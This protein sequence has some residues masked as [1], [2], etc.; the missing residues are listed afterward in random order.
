MNGRVVALFLSVALA[1]GVMGGFVFAA[2]R[3]PEPTRVPAIVL[4]SEPAPASQNESTGGGTQGEVKGKDDFQGEPL[5]GGLSA[6]GGRVDPTSTTRSTSAGD[7]PEEGR[8]GSV[9]ARLA[10]PPAPMPAGNDPEDSGDDDR[11][12]DNG[13][14]DG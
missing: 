4:E 1:V 8:R 6:S 13:E 9:G 2:I 12:E 10:P 11:G 7:D 5:E 3:A 14:T